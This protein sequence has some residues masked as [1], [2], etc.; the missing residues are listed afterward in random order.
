MITKV[1]KDVAKKVKT[2]DVETRQENGFL[3]ELFKDGD[4]T[5]AYLSC[6]KPGGFK[7]YHLHKVRAARY[8]CLKGKM[9]IILYI[10]GKRE[11][12]VLTPDNLTRLYIPPMT[13]TALENVGNEDGWL[14]NYPDPPYDPE[15]KGEQVDFTQKELDSGEY[16]KKL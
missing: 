10:D 12:H 5:V 4:K 1:A 2:Y 13:P 15:L 16:L 3:I 11:E 8:I 7:G 9:K 6:A 14:I